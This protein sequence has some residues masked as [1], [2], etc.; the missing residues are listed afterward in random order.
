MKFGPW[1]QSSK[2]SRRLCARVCRSSASLSF[3]S[4]PRPRALLR[5]WIATMRSSIV[6]RHTSFVTATGFVWPRR[7]HLAAACSSAALFHLRS[8]IGDPNR[9]YGQKSQGDSAKPHAAMCYLPRI[10]EVH[11]VSSNEVQPLPSCPEARQKN[12]WTSPVAL[13]TACNRS[14][15]HEWSGCSAAC[16]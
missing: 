15:A 3:C 16:G 5:S 9:G 2:R 13:R 4:A 10:H 12:N 14:T 7:W 6:P 1:V 11:V 8:G